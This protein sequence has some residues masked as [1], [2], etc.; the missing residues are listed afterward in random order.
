MFQDRQVWQLTRPVVDRWIARNSVFFGMLLHHVPPG[1]RI[2]ELGCGPGRHAIG[3][4]TLGY[5]VVGIDLDPRI[6]AQAQANAAAVAPECGASFRTGDMFDLTAI[7]PAGTF[8]AISHGGVMEHLEL[9]TQHPRV[10]APATGVHAHRRV[11]HSVRQSEEP[12]TV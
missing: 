1:S 8:Q 7:A 5:Q 12:Q 3:A 4:A 9:R 10:A 6:V 11:R 2:L